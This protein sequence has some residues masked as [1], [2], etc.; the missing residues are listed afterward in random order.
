VLRQ[1]GL[2]KDAAI[3]TRRPADATHL[4]ARGVSWR[5]IPALRGHQRP[6]TT[7]RSTQL[8][9]KTCDVG[10]ATLNALMADLSPRRSPGMPEVADVWRR[11]GPDAQ[12]RFG[13][14][15]LPRHRR[16]REA[17][18]HCRTEAL[19][20]QRLPCERCGQE[21]DVYHA[22]RHRSCPQCHH[23]DPEAW[24]EARRL[25]LLPVPYCHVVLTLPQELRELVR[26]HQQ[27][28]Y[29]SWLRAAAPARITLAADAHD[30]GGLIGVLGVLHTWT[31]ALVSP[32]HVHCLV[33]AG[34]LSA[35]QT[36]WRPARQTD[37][38]PVQA[39]STLL[40]G[41][42]RDLV[43]QARPALT[44]PEG[45]WTNG[46]VVYGTPTVQGPEKGLNSLGRSGHRIA[47]TTSRM[48]SLEDGAVCFR[49]QDAQNHRWH[50]M[51]L[52]A[53][54]FMRRFLQHV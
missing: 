32:P 24:L 31:R 43:R 50:T 26:R 37:L 17:I 38:V 40:R 36:A 14:A 12:E 39:L 10:Q 1:S 30:V 8:T 6:R 53:Q 48:V 25:E 35:E 5:V 34:G 44:R 23:Q 2:S 54:E 16:A 13:A 21:P 41:L 18:I 20:G 19:G 7:A 9:P 11:D 47:L 46:G 52:P 42:C 49:Y 15:L 4:L 51:P 3:H 29:D 45:I 27:D 22:C 33:P 28:L